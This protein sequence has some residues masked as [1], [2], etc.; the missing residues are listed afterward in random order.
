M[1]LNVFPLLHGSP[2]LLQKEKTAVFLLFLYMTMKWSNSSFSLSSLLITCDHSSKHLFTTLQLDKDNNIDDALIAGREGGGG[3]GGGGGRVFVCM[4][5]VKS[6]CF[7]ISSCWLLIYST[8]YLH[9]CWGVCMLLACASLC[10]FVHSNCQSTEAGSLLCQGLWG[11]CS[12][13]SQRGIVC[14]IQMLEMAPLFA[15]C[16]RRSRAKRRTVLGFDLT[17]KKQNDK[18]SHQL[19]SSPPPPSLL[20]PRRPTLQ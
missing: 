6:N 4:W 16:Y 17:R 14:E 8:V 15:Y 12:N 3:V 7:Y 19:S 10:T 5:H 1:S 11:E 9:L 18:L 20:S 13:L 2:G